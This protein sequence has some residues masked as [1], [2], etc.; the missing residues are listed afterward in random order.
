MSKKTRTIKAFS[1]IILKYMNPCGDIFFKEEYCPLCIVHIKREKIELSPGIYAKKKN[2]DFQLHSDCRGCPL[3]SRGGSTGCIS[4]RTYAPAQKKYYQMRHITLNNAPCQE[5]KN[6]ANFFIK[7]FHTI[8]V[9]PE[10]RFTKK[11]WEYSG[12]EISRED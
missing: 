10:S 12:N 6:R 9:W 4:F 1:E 8:S 7:Y 3:A 2:G 11:G 5:F